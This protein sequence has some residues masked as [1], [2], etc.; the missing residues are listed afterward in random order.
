[1][2]PHDSTAE[3]H[4]LVAALQDSEYENDLLNRIASE[5]PTFA[6]LVLDSMKSMD[7]F[8]DE[9]VATWLGSFADG[10]PKT[11]IQLVVTQ[12]HEFTIDED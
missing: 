1:M 6:A 10:R 9:H 3:T 8:G 7:E 2:K 12:N 4:G 11:Q 5:S